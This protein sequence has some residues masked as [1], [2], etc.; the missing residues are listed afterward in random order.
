MVESAKRLFGERENTAQ[1]LPFKYVVIPKTEQRLPSGSL[2]ESS[3][4]PIL[5]ICKTVS[6]SD[7]VGLL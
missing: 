1:T 2:A 6:E 3:S 5:G 4:E 7:E